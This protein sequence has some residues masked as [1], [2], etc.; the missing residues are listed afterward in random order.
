[1]STLLIGSHVQIFFHRVSEHTYNTHDILHSVASVTH[2][3]HVR[4]ARPT[5]VVATVQDLYYSGLFDTHELPTCHARF[6]VA[7]LMPR[8][9]SDVVGGKSGR[10]HPTSR[11]HPIQKPSN[12]K[13]F[14]HQIRK[15]YVR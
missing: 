11:R 12:I 1:M 5:S 4:Y 10:N 9:A 14:D 8:L 15:K 3:S 13:D 2:Y 7:D 6:T